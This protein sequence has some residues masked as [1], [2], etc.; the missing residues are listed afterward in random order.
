MGLEVS[1]E[2]VKEAT[3]DRSWFNFNRYLGV[4]PT[5]YPSLKTAVTVDVLEAGLILAFVML[6]FCFYIVLPGIRGKEVSI[7]ISNHY[8]WP[9]INLLQIFL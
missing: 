7:N 8:G 1:T 3:I 6:A 9:F 5:Q 2:A 4:W